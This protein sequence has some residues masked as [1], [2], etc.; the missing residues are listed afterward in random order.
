MGSVSKQALHQSQSPQA[1]SWVLLPGAVVATGR[2]S[3]HQNFGSLLSMQYCQHGHVA[4][5]VAAKAE[6]VAVCVSLP[7]WPKRFQ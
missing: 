7:V 1:M 4:C 2:L 6:P 5:L 3:H